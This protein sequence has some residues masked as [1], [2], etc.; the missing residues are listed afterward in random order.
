[1]HSNNIHKKNE[2]TKL[3]CRII[4]P[5]DICEK[6]DLTTYVKLRE[7]LTYCH[8]LKIEYEEKHFGDTSGKLEEGVTLTHILDSIRESEMSSDAFWK[9][10]K[11]SVWI[12]Q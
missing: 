4:C 3:Q 2:R 5:V 11:L 7:R 8:G 9:E 6:K 1:M 10:K 12:K